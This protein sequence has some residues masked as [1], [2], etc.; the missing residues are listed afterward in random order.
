[1]NPQILPLLQQIAQT[2]AE[3][4]ELKF[5]KFNSTLFV[6]TYLI[7]CIYYQLNFLFEV[8]VKKETQKNWDNIR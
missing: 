5:S 6:L 3:T 7:S 4:W 8:F 2:L 1:M